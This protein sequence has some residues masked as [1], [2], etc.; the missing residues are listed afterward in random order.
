[1]I[2]AWLFIS[3]CLPGSQNS[4]EVYTWGGYLYQRFSDSEE[5][6]PLDNA[7][8][9]LSYME[10]DDVVFATQ[11][12]EDAQAYWTFE[13]AD[14]TPQDIQIRI[15]AP[16]CDPMIWRG[17]SPT[18]N[19]I[20]LN[21]FTHHQEYNA[22]FFEQLAPLIPEGIQDLTLAESSHLWGTPLSPEDWTEISAWVSHS[23]GDSYEVLFWG[24]T[25]NLELELLEQPLTKTPLIFIAPNLSPGQV[26]LHVEGP[27]VSAQTVYQTDGGDLLS[28]MYYVL[29]PN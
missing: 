21:L 9:S 25:E 17:Q 7:T 19:T 13:L 24:L 15:E 6:L 4:S 18:S 5:L 20:W 11:P 10:H 23:N 16:D 27:Q 22:L 3:A 2:V 8:L 26:T 1:M 29:W 12:Y 28:A 14:T